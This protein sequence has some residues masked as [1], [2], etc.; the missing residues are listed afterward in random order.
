MI[1]NAD[2]SI[3]RILKERQLKLKSLKPMQQL[4]APVSP[5]VVA[6][7]QGPACYPV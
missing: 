6:K 1:E 7:Q 4:Q 2:A 3:G 5:R